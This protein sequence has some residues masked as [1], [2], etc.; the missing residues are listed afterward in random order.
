MSELSGSCSADIAAD[1]QRCW[2]VV[3]DVERWP[4]WQQTLEDLQVVERDAEGRPVVCDTVSDAKLT[5][6]SVRVGVA[7]EP[8]RRIAWSQIASD[9]LDS[10]HG[11]WELDDL[12][13]GR[14]RA[15]YRLS[16]DPGRIGLL[17][18]PMERI[19]RP[20]VMGH[21]AD[22]LAAELARSS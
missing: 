11:S 8:P 16:V 19:I 9:H 7:Y 17:A 1:V 2:A 13:G 10:M 6:V 21:Q 4:Q 12:G 5:R 18:R 3:Q 20:L 22:E 15:T 14:T